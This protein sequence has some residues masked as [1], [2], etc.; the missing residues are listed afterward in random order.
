MRP[1]LR[2][3]YG[4]LCRDDTPMV[5]RAAAHNLGKF[6]ERVEPQ[7]ISRELIPLFQDLT[8]DGALMS[9]MMSSF[10]FGCIVF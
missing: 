9:M 3:L 5:R 4:Q 1:E 2:S 6:A 8:V 7:C 10:A